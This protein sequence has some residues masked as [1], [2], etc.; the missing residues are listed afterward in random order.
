MPHPSSRTPWRL[1]VAAAL[2]LAALHPAA[3][4]DYRM[5]DGFEFS[6]SPCPTGGPSRPDKILLA[7]LYPAKY[8]DFELI[9]FGSN[10]MIDIVR[11]LTDSINKRD[12]ILAGVEVEVEFVPLA[13]Q[14]GKAFESAARFV[15]NQ[16]LYEDL[17]GFLGAQTDANSITIQYVAQSYKVPQV[18]WS[19]QTSILSNEARFPFF[20]RTVGSALELGTCISQMLREFNVTAVALLSDRDTITGASGDFSFE[21]F[22]ENGVEVVYSKILPTTVTDTTQYETTLREIKASGA[23]YIIAYIN[24]ITVARLMITNK[25]LGYIVSRSS[26]WVTDDTMIDV[27][28]LI[29]LLVN[30]NI[31]FPEDWGITVPPAEMWGIMHG[32]IIMVPGDLEN[33]AFDELNGQVSSADTSLY[34]NLGQELDTSSS[35]TMRLLDAFHAIVYA[36]DAMLRSGR[37]CQVNGPQRNGDAVFEALKAVEFEGYSGPVR[38]DTIGDRLTPMSVYNI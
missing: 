2:L 20:A 29:N 34:R 26:V 8:N 38:F 21:S 6:S 32:T 14:A 7:C 37:G 35:S 36:V 19:S 5:R 16:T 4:L 31:P 10:A 17:V 1:F 23:I 30:F 13:V 11:M 25:D 33:S 12:D 18:S 28:Q 27:Q 15:F 9:N 24:P 22:E 3:T